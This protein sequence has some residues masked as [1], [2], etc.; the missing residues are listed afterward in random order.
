MVGRGSPRSKTKWSVIILL[1]LS[2]FIVLLYL[3]STG[4]DVQKKSTSP[5]AN[6]GRLTPREYNFTFH[7]KA[8]TFHTLREEIYNDQEKTRK[9]KERCSA[10]SQHDQVHFVL[11]QQVIRY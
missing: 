9:I 7:E 10:L 5:F 3:S 6:F 8:T 2:I 1:S 11:F 4:S